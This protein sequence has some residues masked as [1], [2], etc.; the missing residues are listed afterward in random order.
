V[1]D[2]LREGL[3]YAWQEPAIRRTLALVALSSA[4]VLPYAALLP[5]FATRVFHGGPEL[6]GLLN[7]A[8]AIGAVLGGLFLASRREQ[9][10]LDRRIFIAGIVTPAAA[11]A[12]AFAPTLALALPALALLGG[13]QI[14][15]MASMNTRLQTVVRD[16]MRGRVMSFFNMAFMAAL[17]LGQLVFGAASDRFGVTRVV[18]TGAFLAL[19][20]N[21]LLHRRERPTPALTPSVAG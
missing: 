5:L 20:G 2:E 10:G 18:A 17:P 12:L 21:L 9:S 16:S 14:S 3:R 19:V 7:A 1:A 8:P 6:L 13:A 15:W 4:T 11:I